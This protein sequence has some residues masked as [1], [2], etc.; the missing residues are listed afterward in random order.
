MKQE[1]EPF[2][3]AEIHLYRQTR[4]CR[5]G[6][7]SSSKKSAIKA[8]L[9]ISGTSWSKDATVQ[10]QADALKSKDDPSQLQSK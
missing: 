5:E 2:Q 7:S 10:M 6:T 8:R 4:W 3:L 9:V 1:N